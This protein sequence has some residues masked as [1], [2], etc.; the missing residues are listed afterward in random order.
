[1]M[2]ASNVNT[3]EV[4]PTSN[5]TLVLILILASFPAGTLQVNEESEVQ[6]LGLHVVYVNFNLGL[7]SATPKAAPNTETIIPPALAE[8][9]GLAPVEV[10]MPY[11]KLR[12][13]VLTIK[14]LL[15]QIE[16][17]DAVPLDAFETIEESQTQMVT[18]LEE[19]PDFI[20]LEKLRP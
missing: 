9:A 6:W 4:R 14:T 17:K 12:V 15:T 8:F 19:K 10:G 20:L 11:E 18:E 1:M 2:G 7:A 16:W 5:E 13:I 3:R